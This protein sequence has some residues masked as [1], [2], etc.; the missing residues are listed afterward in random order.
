MTKHYTKGDLTVVWKP[1][2]CQHSTI[3]WKGLL[4]VFDPRKSP[5]IDMDGADAERIREQ[6][7]QCPSGA[8]SFTEK[9]GTQG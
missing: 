2:I 1:D 3:C 4:S 9:G 5:W 8:L 6:V 7:R